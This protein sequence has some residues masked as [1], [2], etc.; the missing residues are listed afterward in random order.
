MDLLDLAQQLRDAV[1][2]DRVR[3]PECTAPMFIS[4]VETH[5]GWSTRF[6]PVLRT[7]YDC[8]DGSC[9]GRRTFQEV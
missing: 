5:E 1:G 4:I 2:D 7:S 9:S 8:T 3:C 6:K